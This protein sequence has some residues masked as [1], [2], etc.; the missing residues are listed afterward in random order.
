LLRR[1]LL[2]LAV[3]LLVLGRASA[4]QVLRIGNGSEPATLDPALSELQPDL[5]ILHEVTEGLVT[6]GPAGEALPGQA[7]SWTVSDDALTYRFTLRPDLHWSNGAPLKAEDFAW[8]WRRTVDP[9]TGS[10]YAFPF[11]PILNAEEI[12]TGKAAPETLGV[13]AIDD[14]TLEVRLKAPTGFFAKLVGLPQFSPAY[15]P[16][17]EQYGPQYTRAGNFVGNGAFL[18]AEWTPQSRVVVA[19][20]PYY[21]GAAAVKLD[22]VEYLPIE[23]QNEE[24]KRYRAGELDVT[25]DVPTDQ[26]DFVPTPSVA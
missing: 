26:L 21:W 22:K 1:C 12:V 25:M 24:L 6:I 5:Q 3:S 8:S 18:L 10:K 23:N 7:E 13:R 17:V 14:R 9:K 20:N 11:Y 4:E 16:A 2:V 15:R 19:R